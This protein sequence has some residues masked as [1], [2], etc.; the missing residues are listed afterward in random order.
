VLGISDATQEK[1]LASAQQLVATCSEQR[2]AIAT[3]AAAAGRQASDAIGDIVT[4]VQSAIAN[5]D[6]T[7]F[8]PSSVVTSLQSQVKTL[9]D[10]ENA[11]IVDEAIAA[12]KIIPAQREWAI[13]LQAQ[14]PQQL[15]AFLANQPAMLGDA[16]TLNNRPP[17]AADGSLDQEDLALCSAMGISPEEFKKQREKERT[18]TT[19]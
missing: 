5:P 3:M 10:R 2:Q 7:K 17:G 11:R 12:G 8:V 18:A 6:A 13:A 14:N 1:V 4:S 19:H 9:L 16:T 15:Q